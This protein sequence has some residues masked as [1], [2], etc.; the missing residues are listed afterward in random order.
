MDHFFSLS[1][2]IET[3]PDECIWPERK[4]KTVFSVDHLVP[5]RRVSLQEEGIM[6][7]A[8]CGETF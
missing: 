5:K 1:V 7:N 6:G 4:L 8:V 3:L 2:V